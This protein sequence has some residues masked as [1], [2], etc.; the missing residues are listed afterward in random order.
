MRLLC[1]EFLANYIFRRICEYAV[2]P[3][4]Q[5]FP[6]LGE[7]CSIFLSL[8]YSFVSIVIVHLTLEGT[9]S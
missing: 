2:L 1:M 5:R 4:F 7:Q 6:H 3:F 9:T 8:L